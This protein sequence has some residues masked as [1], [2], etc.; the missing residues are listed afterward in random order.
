MKYLAAMNVTG[1][2]ELESDMERVDWAGFE[3]SL[4]NGLVFR[5]TGIDLFHHD[6]VYL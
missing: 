6:Y 2:W 3:I 4:L 1:K 5:I